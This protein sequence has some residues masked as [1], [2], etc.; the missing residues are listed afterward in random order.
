M[1]EMNLNLIPSKAKFQAARIKLQKRVR[2]IITVVLVVWFTSGVIIFSLSGLMKVRASSATANKKKVQEN[3]NSMQDNIVTSQKLKYKAK[4]VG[5]VLDSRFEYGRSFE[6][7]GQLFPSAIN[8]RNYDL[9]EDGVFE[10][11]GTTSEKI[12]VDLLE[13]TVSVV[14]R[15]DNEKLKNAKITSLAI[16]DGVWDFS[17]EVTLK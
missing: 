5:G 17:M 12:N 2:L 15:G 1:S 8:I 6:I 11:K 9:K 10:I 16:K 3:Y 7:V 13:E 14:N 4:M